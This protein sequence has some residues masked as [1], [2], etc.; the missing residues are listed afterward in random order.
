MIV[1]F[2]SGL[3][4]SHHLGSARLKDVDAEFEAAEAFQRFDVDGDG[5]ITVEDLQA[6]RALL[7]VSNSGLSYRRFRTH[8]SVGVHPWRL[9]VSSSGNL[10]CFCSI[11]DIP[12]VPTGECTF[13]RSY[14][15]RRL[16]RHGQGM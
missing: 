6:V 9:S 1:C 2:G 16:A 13:R 11:N 14:C 12:I 10:W 3:S 15:Y 5:F 7:L 8:V 4:L